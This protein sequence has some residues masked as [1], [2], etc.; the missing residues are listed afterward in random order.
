LGEPSSEFGYWR[1]GTSLVIEYVLITDI[2]ST[3]TKAAL[4]EVEENGDLRSW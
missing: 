1:G 4:R 2:G 3:T